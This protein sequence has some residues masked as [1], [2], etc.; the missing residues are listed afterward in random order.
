MYLECVHDLGKM[1]H[2][3]LA[4]LWNQGQY[5]VLVYVHDLSKMVHNSLAFSMEPRTTPCIRMC[6]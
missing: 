3:S 4:I 6:T 1:V 5:Y 2:N